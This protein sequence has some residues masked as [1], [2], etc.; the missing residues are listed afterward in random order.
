MSQPAIQFRNVTKHFFLQQDRTIKDLIPSL[1]KGFAVGKSHKVLSKVSFEIQAGETIAIVG[2]NGAGKSTIMKLIAGVT[3][4]NKGK[5][6]V[7]GKVAPLIEIGAG[8]HHELTG[9]ENIFLNAAILGLHKKEIQ[10]EIGKI[11]EFSELG[12]YIHEPVKRYSSGMYMRLAFSVAIHTNAP[13][14]LIDEVLAV[15][16]TSFQEKCLMRLNEIK[17][18]KDRTI[19]FVSH[20]EDAVTWFC[21]RAILLHQGDL[22]ADDTPDKVFN[23]YHKI[24]ENEK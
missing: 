21:E 1:I 9:Y 13:I 12:E 24:L 11:I 2:R 10:A 3:Y 14:L 6:V 4:P 17:R 16:D 7:N 23:A 8:F 18:Q 22:V 19:V 15:G 20:D 5:V